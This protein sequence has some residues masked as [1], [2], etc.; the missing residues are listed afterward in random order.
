LKEPLDRKGA[1]K[2]SKSRLKISF[3]HKT[4]L[5]RGSEIPAKVKISMKGRGEVFQK[6]RKGTINKGTLHI[7][8]EL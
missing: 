1:E 2:N 7:S 3:I 4:K 6:G 5:M 8:V